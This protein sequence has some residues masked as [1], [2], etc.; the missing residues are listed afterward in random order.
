MVIRTRD[1][2]ELITEPIHASDN[3]RGSRTH[4][5]RLT[6]EQVDLIGAFAALT[7]MGQGLYQQAM[8]G[9]HDILESITDDPDYPLYAC[10]VVQLTVDYHSADGHTLYQVIATDCITINV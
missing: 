10:D 2:A 7:G 4:L 8:S 6:D 9:F 5:V 3:P 1:S